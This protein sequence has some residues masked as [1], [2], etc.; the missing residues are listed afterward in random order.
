MERRNPARKAAGLLFAS[1]ALWSAALAAAPGDPLGPPFSV[2]LYQSDTERP[3][4]AIAGPA[5]FKLFWTSINGNTSPNYFTRFDATGAR[6][7]GDLATP[8]DVDDVA[9]APDGRYV[10]SY[11]AYIGSR[12]VVLAQ[13]YDAN[14]VPVGPALEV[15]DPAAVLGPLTTST[16]RVAMNASGDFVVTWV[17]AKLVKLLS[18]CGGGFGGPRTCLTTYQTTVFARRYAADGTPSAAVTV[19]TGQEISAYVLDIGGDFGLLNREAAVALADDGSFA[20]TWIS[21]TEATTT[22]R[23]TQVKLRYF[24][25]G[26][27]AQLARTVEAASAAEVPAVAMDGAGNI[28]VAYRKHAFGDVNEVTLWLRRYATATGNALGPAQRIDTGAT[29]EQGDMLRLIA[30]GGGACAVA[31]ADQDL[32]V[33]LQRY[34]AD[35]S[36]LGGK[37]TVSGSGTYFGSVRLAAA[38]GRL[39]VTWAQS[40]NPFAE[41]DVWARVYETP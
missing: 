35:G 7:S 16:S 18:A 30:T 19:N 36:A 15:T 17:Q 10:T 12:Y 9:S 11:G 29:V 39:M 24:P 21:A 1:L 38:N 26:A 28:V 13:R 41:N 6:L 8:S 25:A 5:G 40:P 4:G 37:L 31:W 27:N 23:N 14:D 22:L 32:G 20:V 34:A 3:R 33:F 2:N